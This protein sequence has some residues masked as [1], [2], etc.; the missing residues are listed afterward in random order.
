[1]GTKNNPGDFD[2]YAAADP[3]EETF[4]LLAR[5]VDAPARVQEWATKRMQRALNPNMGESGRAHE[6]RKADEAF[7]CARRMIEQH[8]E[9]RDAL[10][11]GI[12][13]AEL[14]RRRRSSPL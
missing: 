7:A 2:C 9:V 14:R 5:D 13:L 12:T 4:I 11:Q 8:E 10:R 6:L 3:D 1:M